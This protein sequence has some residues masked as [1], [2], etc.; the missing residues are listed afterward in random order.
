MNFIRCEFSET[1]QNPVCDIDIFLFDT[2][3][4]II[5]A[6]SDNVII[7]ECPTI[8]VSGF[9]TKNKTMYSYQSI[10]ID[11][12]SVCIRRGHTSL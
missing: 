2:E 6:S 9:Y 12:F 7:G 11:N 10:G 1:Y 5:N 8:M 3:A 4:D